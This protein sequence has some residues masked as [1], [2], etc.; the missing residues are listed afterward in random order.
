LELQAMRLTAVTIA[1]SVNA[2]ICGDKNGSFREFLDTLGG[3]AKDINEAL[4]QAKKDGL[5]IEEN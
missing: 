2:A 4:D 5:P 3:E 1:M